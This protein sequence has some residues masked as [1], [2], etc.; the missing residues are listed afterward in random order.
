VYID[1]QQYVDINVDL[2]ILPFTIDRPHKA[3]Y[4]SLNIVNPRRWQRKV[5]ETCGLAFVF[6][7][8]VHFVG[9]KLVY[10]RN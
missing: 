8:L 2:Y 7:I 5:T 1:I 6:Q 9:N 3:L 10:K 4:M